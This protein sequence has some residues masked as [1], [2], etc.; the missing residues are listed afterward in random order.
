[1]LNR[2]ARQVGK[3]YDHNGEIAASG[4][5]VPELFDS[6][7]KIEFYSHKGPRSLG[8][9]WVDEVFMPVADSFDIPVN[10]KMR[11]VCEH[12]ASMIADPLESRSRYS[13]LV[14]GGGAKNRFLADLIAKKAAPLK[15]VIPGD[16]LTD[17][18]E[19]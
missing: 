3:Q 13:M 16:D 11:T 12:I 5:V 7:G 6:L 4:N 2:L 17:F 14:T 8:R 18:K 9:E 19:A 15:T 1:V 10:D